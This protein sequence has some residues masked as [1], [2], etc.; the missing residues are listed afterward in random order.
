MTGVL[1]WVVGFL[2]GVGF[3]AVICARKLEELERRLFEAQAEIASA[4][5]VGVWKGGAV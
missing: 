1:V 3:M 2:C 4:R 5:A